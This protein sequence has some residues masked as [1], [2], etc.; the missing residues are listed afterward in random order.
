VTWK[1]LDQDQFPAGG[2]AAPFELQSSDQWQNI[3]VTVPVKGTTGIVRLYLPA[4]KSM[5]EIESIEFRD[6]DSHERLR[7]WDFAQSTTKRD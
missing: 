5:I 3:Q 2:Q 1:T 6:A 7:A 4:Q